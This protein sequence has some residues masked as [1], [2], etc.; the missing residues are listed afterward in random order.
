M[1]ADSACHTTGLDTAGEDSDGRPWADDPRADAKDALLRYAVENR[2]GAAIINATRAMLDA[3][4]DAGDA[5]HRLALRF[6]DENAEWFKTARLDGLEWVWPRT[7]AFTRPANKHSPKPGEGTGGSDDTERTCEESSRSPRENAREYLAG[8][9][10]VGTDGERG[11][12]LDALATYRET[13]EGRYT[14]LD[15]IR[16]DGAE[17]LLLP[18]MTRFNAPSRV[19]EA[20]E[21]LEGAFGRAS[22]DYGRGVVLTVTTDPSR[23]DSVADAADG[24]LADVGRLKSWLATDGRLGERPPS[25]VVPEWTNRGVPHAHVVLFGVSWAVSH[26][27]LRAYWSGSRD[28]GKIV[29]FDRIASRSVGGRWRWGD[30]EGPTDAGGRSPRRYLSKGLDALDGLASSPPEDVRAAA[31]A[32]RSGS[33]DGSSPTRPEGGEGGPEGDA[34]AA[35]DGREWWRLACYWAVDMRLF[36]CSPSLK[37]DRDGSTDTDLPHVPCYEYVGTARLGEFPGYVRERAVVLTRDGRG[38]GSG[39]ASGGGR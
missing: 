30:G 4:A 6:Y 10:A 12:L 27:A 39:S 28:R 24:L 25:V 33:A 36:T 19:G 38:R 26:A 23:Y 1:S 18:Y 13:T 15:R 14:R 9:S 3:D 29:W 21:R 34:D 35:A 17:T 37:T 11:K 8:R 7:P 31:R 22:E 20:R 16:G 5:N 32:L 2:E